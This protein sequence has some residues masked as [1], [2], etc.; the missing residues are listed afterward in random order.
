MCDALTSVRRHM[1]AF[2]VVGIRLV[3]PARQ[4][5]AIAVIG[6]MMIVTGVLGILARLRVRIAVGAVRVV[7][8]LIV[9]LRVGLM[10]RLRVVI[11]VLRGG[12][13]RQPLRRGPVLLPYRIERLAL[14]QIR[15]WIA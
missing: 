7:L 5:D 9:R 2:G 4:R 14:G 1:A 10:R 15:E 6:R 12:R 3:L 8:R 11:V 13:T